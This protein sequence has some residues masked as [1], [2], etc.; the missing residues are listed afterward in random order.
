[1]KHRE[2]KRVIIGMSGASG[3]I[4]GVR[5]LE[6]LRSI[7]GI[8]THLVLTG[9]AV[10]TAKIECGIIGKDL[11]KMSDYVHRIG[12]IAAPIASGSFTTDGMII[13]PCSVKTLSGVASCFAE[14]LLL[15]AADVCLK[16]RR[17]LVLLVRETPLHHGHLRLMVE[18]TDMGAI[19][20]PPVPSFYSFPKTVD[21]IVDHTAGRLLDVF[22]IR[23]PNG[24]VKRWTGSP[25]PDRMQS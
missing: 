3:A 25:A 12:D 24:L 20:M 16:E 5:L 9:S 19:I 18:A 15:R 2:P 7:E 23:P 6:I 1:M 22:G 4:Y 10:K 14:N 8:E 17:K 13:A 11:H 21:E